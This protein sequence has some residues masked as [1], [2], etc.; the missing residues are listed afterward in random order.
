MTV[1]GNGKAKKHGRAPL[2]RRSTPPRAGKLPLS[3]KAKR[4]NGEPCRSPI[5][6]KSG[7]CALHDPSRLE[8]TKELRAKAGKTRGDQFKQDARKKKL[9]KFTADGQVR[10]AETLD[11]LAR[12][13]GN[14]MRDVEQNK[15]DPKQGSCVLYGAGILRQCLENKAE[16][17]RWRSDDEARE[18]L[19][20]GLAVIFSTKRVTK[21]LGGR[22]GGG[23]DE[24][25]DEETG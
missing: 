17:E 13:V 7:Y 24:R 5:V 18:Y 16:Q 22:P 14:V 12:V 20:R 15:L 4:T 23:S 11:D 1:K 6:G 8:A 21:Q 25:T 19:T 9:L 3:C 10:T 2:A